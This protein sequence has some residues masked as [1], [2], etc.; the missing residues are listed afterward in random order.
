MAGKKKTP[1]EAMYTE[2]D[3]QKMFCCGAIAGIETYHIRLS[4]CRRE[5]NID[6]LREQAK[7][8]LKNCGDKMFSRTL[9]ET[10]LTRAQYRRK[11]G[12]WA[13]PGDPPDIGMMK[14]APLA[15]SKAAK[16]GK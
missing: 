12:C 11:H 1:S 14:P 4:I 3:L 9:D 13:I 6:E 8:A 5:T 16:A 15:K 10:K 7:I 2:D